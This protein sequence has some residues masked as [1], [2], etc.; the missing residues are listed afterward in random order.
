MKKLPPTKV[1]ICGILIWVSTSLQGAEQETTGEQPATEQEN[2]SKNQQKAAKSEP[3]E[4]EQSSSNESPQ[5]ENLKNRELGTAF[6]RFRPSEEISADNAVPF[7]V[8]I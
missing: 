7:P 4:S 3:S 6:R 5:A 8:D 1:L 2:A